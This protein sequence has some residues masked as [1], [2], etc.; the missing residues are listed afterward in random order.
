MKTVF[1]LMVIR[2][3]K[4]SLRSLEKPRTKASLQPSSERSIALVASKSNS[5]RA[6]Y[7]TDQDEQEEFIDDNFDAREEQGLSSMLG[8]TDEEEASPLDYHSYSLLRLN[9]CKFENY[10]DFDLRL[11]APGRNTS[12][13]NASSTSSRKE[14]ET[15]ASSVL[16]S[17]HSLIHYKLVSLLSE[18]RVSSLYNEK[19]SMLN[20]LPASFEPAGPYRFFVGHPLKSWGPQNLRDPS[21]SA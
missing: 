1:E 2:R 6:A 10:I 9:L 11:P 14:K 20:L 19:M 15:I 12:N 18:I 7:Q 17:N 21:K 3:A 13:L 8:D 5:F 4:L 16:D